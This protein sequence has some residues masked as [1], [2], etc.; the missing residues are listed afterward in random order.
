MKTTVSGTKTSGFSVS[1][2]EGWG[3]IDSG[4]PT[5]W[6]TTVAT[7]FTTAKEAFAWAAEYE[8]SQA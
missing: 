7:G 1:V 6:G 5:F 4:Y 8:G 2:V 3:K